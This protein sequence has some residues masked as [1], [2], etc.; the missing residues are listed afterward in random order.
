MRPPSV[1]VANGGG[2][3]G[4]RADPM[5]PTASTVWDAV[6]TPVERLRGGGLR[7]GAAMHHLR[8]T[9]SGALAVWRLTNLDL[10]GFPG[11]MLCGGDGLARAVGPRPLPDMK[12]HRG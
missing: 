3:T 12:L 1:S 7:S 2:R 5:G 9:E 6:V 4:S 11:F 10:L 8:R